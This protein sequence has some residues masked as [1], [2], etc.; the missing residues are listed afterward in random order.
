MAYGDEPFLFEVGSLVAHFSRLKDMRHA[1]GRCYSRV[2]HLMV[3]A[4]LAGH[5]KPE[6][7]ADWARPRTEGLVKLLKLKRAT[8]PYP[9]TYGRVLAKAVDPHPRPLL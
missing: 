6:V 7:L 2:L 4:K 3:L 8:M 9:M 1:R 5:D